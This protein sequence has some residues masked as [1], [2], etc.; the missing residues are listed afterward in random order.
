MVDWIDVCCKTSMYDFAYYDKVIHGSLN[1]IITIDLVGILSYVERP[2]Y[3]QDLPH[4]P[5]FGDYVP[6]VDFKIKNAR[7]SMLSFWNACCGIYTLA[8][9]GE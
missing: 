3:T 4:D 1:S 7:A 2:Y 8:E 9:V 6:F 5:L